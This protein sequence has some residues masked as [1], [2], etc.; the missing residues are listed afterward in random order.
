MVTLAS[1]GGNVIVQRPKGVSLITLYTND[2]TIQ[3]GVFVTCNGDS[4]PDC[5]RVDAG[6]EI[7]V[8]VAIERRDGTAQDPDVVIADDTPITI[9]PCGS[10]M[11][12]YAIAL[13]SRGAILPG[14]FLMMSGL[15]GPIKG[16]VAAKMTVNTATVFIRGLLYQ[17]VGRAVEYDADVAAWDYVQVRLCI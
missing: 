9:A 1:K 4:A 5:N 10:G 11:V 7:P 16:T 12:V 13:T 8:G 15:K 14:D 17:N 2:T 6:G 3:P